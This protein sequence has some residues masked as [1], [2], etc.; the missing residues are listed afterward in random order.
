MMAAWIYV[1]AWFAYA[2]VAATKKLVHLG[3]APGGVR[4]HR[5]QGPGHAARCTGRPADL[6]TLGGAGH[7]EAGR[8][9][10]R[11]R[12]GDEHVHRRQAHPG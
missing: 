8:L 2:S 11:R 5:G 6:N 9:R 12:R 7:L 1:L 3:L 10:R 4:R